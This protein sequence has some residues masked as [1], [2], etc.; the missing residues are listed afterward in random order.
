MWAY[1]GSEG[2]ARTWA[3]NVGLENP[4]LVDEDSDLRSAY[5]IPNSDEVFA[6][7]PRHYI[8]GAD[9]RFTFIQTTVAPEALG[10]AIVEALE[11]AD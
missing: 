3:E 8:I 11:D 1:A 2:G 9:G 7:N 4:V 6:A 5:F 10:E